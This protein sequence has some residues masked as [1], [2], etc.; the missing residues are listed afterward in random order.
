MGV[1]SKSLKRRGEHIGKD[2][3]GEEDGRLHLRMIQSKVTSDCHQQNS[4]EGKDERRY[5]QLTTRF[6]KVGQEELELIRVCLIGTNLS[7]LKV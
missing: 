1:K 5:L 7:Q 2:S 6:L 4:M 3:E